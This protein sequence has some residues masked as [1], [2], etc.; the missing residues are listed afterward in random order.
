M[1]ES[2]SSSGAKRRERSRSE[3]K[4]QTN[5]L[6]ITNLDGKV[7]A[8]VFRPISRMSRMSSRECL[9]SLVLLKTLLRKETAIQTIA[10]LLQR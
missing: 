5:K 7:G 1:S 2:S 4:H 6:F 10:L 3:D 9:K 8:L